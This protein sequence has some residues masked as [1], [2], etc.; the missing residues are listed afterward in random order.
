V[1]DGVREKTAGNDGEKI[2]KKECKKQAKRERER[3]LFKIT[4]RCNADLG[5]ISDHLCVWPF[6]FFK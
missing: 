4:R 3:E 2:E 1:W 5:H 6:T